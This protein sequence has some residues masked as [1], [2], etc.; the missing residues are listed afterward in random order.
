MEPT[1]SVHAYRRVQKDYEDIARKYD[2]LRKLINGNW[3]DTEAVQEAM[4]ITFSEGMEMFD[5]GR[6]A[7]WNKAPLNGQRV[8]TKFRLCEKTIKPRDSVAFLSESDIS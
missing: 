1:V 2:T 7:V 3:V 8:I 4:G 5:F 6:M